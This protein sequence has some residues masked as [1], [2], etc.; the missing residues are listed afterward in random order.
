ML[1]ARCGLD[2]GVNG[3][4]VQKLGTGFQGVASA[5]SHLAEPQRNMH[6]GSVEYNGSS[7]TTG[8][9]VA[10]QGAWLFGASLTK[11]L[12]P[13]IQVGGDLTLVAVGGI[14]PI[15][16]VGLRYAEGKDICGATISRT[17]DPKLPPG[18][19]AHE[20]RLN[21]VRKVSERLAL[22]TEY[23]IS[24]PDKESGLSMG[25]EYTFRQ[26]RVQGLLDTD[27]KVSCCVSDFVGFGFSGMIDYFRNDYKFGVVMH[28]LPQPEQQQQQP[29]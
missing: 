18:T 29:M 20:C 5:N 15:M 13:Q 4:L 11:K 3:R 24:H 7:F 17:P 26:A 12:L 16:Q 8:G 21:Y 23:K 1:V 2:G 19:M 14:M 25:Y 28:V 22:G 9:K 10:W 27:G 6:E